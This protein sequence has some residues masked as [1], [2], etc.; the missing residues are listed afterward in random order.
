M[1]NE[2]DDKP[3]SKRGRPKGSKVEQR[4]VKYT[5]NAGECIRDNIPFIFV[6]QF[7][8][9]RA[10]SIN[11]KWILDKNYLPIGIE[12]D[13][14]PLAQSPTSQ[15]KADSIKFITAYGWGQPVQST[16]VDVEIRARIDQMGSGV[17]N[18]ELQ[19]TYNPRAL[20]LLQAALREGGT[21]PDVIDAEWTDAPEEPGNGLGRENTE[22]PSETEQLSTVNEVLNKNNPLPE[23]DSGGSDDQ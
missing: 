19:A 2:K 13:P 17:S 11:P 4:L 21:S 15:E 18:A 7:H 3:K 10:A 6:L 9:M 5:L 8:A 23:T 20:K 1:A 14:S 16:Q 22:K 12:P